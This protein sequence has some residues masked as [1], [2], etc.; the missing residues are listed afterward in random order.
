[1]QV[2]AYFFLRVPEEIKIFQQ[3][4]FFILMVDKL[5]VKFC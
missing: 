1:M 4:I 3:E 5:I 2:T